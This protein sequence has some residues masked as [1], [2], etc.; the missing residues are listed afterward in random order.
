MVSYQTISHFLGILVHCEPPS[1]YP[2]L[3]IVLSFGFI[4]HLLYFCDYECIH[5]ISLF[6]WRKRLILH[7]QKLTISLHNMLL[8]AVTV[9]PDGGLTTKME[10]KNVRISRFRLCVRRLFHQS[11]WS[12]T[13]PQSIIL[14]KKIPYT[15][16]IMRVKI[17]LPVLRSVIDI[18][19]SFYS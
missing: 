3:I 4:L 11:R 2:A 6:I 8:K 10:L 16:Q 12:K 17:L 1:A 13:M 18:S 7:N 15:V 14:L 9:R 19:S 5:I